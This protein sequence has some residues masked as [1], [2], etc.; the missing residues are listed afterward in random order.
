M[1]GDEN[2][3]IF[4]Q[5]LKKIIFAISKL[6]Y[7][8]MSLC[9]ACSDQA[10][11]FMFGY[12]GKYKVLENGIDLKRFY[13]IDKSREDYSFCVNARFDPQKNPYFII[14]I[15]NEIVK[16][17]PSTFLKWVGAGYM[18][19]D[20]KKYTKELRLEKHV[21]FLGTTENVEKI[22]WNNKYFLFPSKYEG[23]GIVLIE[24]QAA[25]LKCFASDKV[26][27]LA[28]CG[29]VKEISLNKTAKEWA[30][31]ILNE[32]K[33]ETELCVDEE[34]LKKFDIHYT[35]KKLENIYDKI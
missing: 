8:N 7:R 21:E 26:P 17:E 35:V 19:K 32:I 22:L 1:S 23:L 13:C 27:H 2:K 10:G 4:H 25:G 29:G 12:N 9:V 18:E 14:D 16:S 3:K 33:N 31:I 28:N 11:Q 30:D 15:V 34:K 6:I 5:N 24:A 20:I